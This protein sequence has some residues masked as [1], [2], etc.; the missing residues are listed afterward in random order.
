MSR[1]A[2][3]S[4]FFAAGLLL[5]GLA[6]FSSNASAADAAA[7][8][9][10]GTDYELIDPP[11]A[12]GTGDTIEVVE[13]FGY[14]CPHC[15]AFEP[16]L[17][18]WRERQSEDVSFSSMP[19][20]FGGVWELF[21]RAYYAAEASGVL[22]KSHQA[23]FKAVHDDKRIKQPADIPAFYT[24]YG[25]DAET[26]ESTMQSFAVNGRINAAAE[27]VRAM[28]VDGTPSMIVD[29]KYRVT[30]N[31]GQERMLEVVDQLVAMERAGRAAAQ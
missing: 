14:S 8:L 2:A 12:S 15:A 9:V 20:V 16:M 21:A 4:P 22:G 1:L 24:D 30:A 27:R 17:Q 13:V 25:I 18:A 28:G 6:T 11:L 23:M 5:A 3:L 29:G 19:A 31:H 10:V 7:P 26:F